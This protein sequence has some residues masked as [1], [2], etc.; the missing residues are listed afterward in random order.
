MEI[1]SLAEGLYGRGNVSPSVSE[2][3]W[4]AYWGGDVA[5][6]VGPRLGLGVSP[7]P[8]WEWLID[9]DLLPEDP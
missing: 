7:A 2:Q 6:R 9:G 8:L 4:E 1:V 5:E 3:L